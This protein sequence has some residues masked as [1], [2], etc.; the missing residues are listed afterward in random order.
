MKQMTETTAPAPPPATT[1]MRRLANGYGSGTL[2]NRL[3]S[4][5]FREFERIVDRVLDANSGGVR[6]IDLGGTNQ[7]WEQRGWAGRSD[8]EIVTVNLFSD[9]KKHA[10]ITPEAGNVTDLSEFADGSFDIVFSNSVIEHLFDKPSQQKMAAEVQR[11]APIYWVQT[12]NF[13]FPVEPHF[14]TVGWQWMPRA[15]RIWLLQRRSFGWCGKCADA[16]TAAGHVDEIRLLRGSE[17]ARMFPRA[18]IVRERVGPFTKS[19]VAVRAS[20][21][22]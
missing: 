8:I 19:L 2:A 13:W 16:E 20:A 5:R 1:F 15:V 4:R 9:E 6:I 17:I 22:A 12:P 3:R 14:L 21:S 10:N 18:E 7:F 11:L